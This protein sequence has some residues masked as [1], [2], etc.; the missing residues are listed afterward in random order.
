MAS[1]MGGGLVGIGRSKARVYMEKQTGVR[2]DDVAGDEAK[3]ELKEIVDFLKDP[4][5]MAGS[6]RA[7]PRACC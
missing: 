6:G 2:F 3:A 5:P 1:R 7:C 4:K